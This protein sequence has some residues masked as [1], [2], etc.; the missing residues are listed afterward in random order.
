MK[1]GINVKRFIS[2]L[3]VSC[4][5]L[6]LCACDSE[7][8]YTLSNV[9]TTGA[10]INQITDEYENDGSFVKILKDCNIDLSGLVYRQTDGS[11]FIGWRDSQT[12]EYLT[13]FSSVTVGTVLEATY[14]EYDNVSEDGD[15]IFENTDTTS[16]NELNFIFSE[17]NVFT[18]ELPEIL[19]VGALVL[20]SDDGGFYEMFLDEP[21]VVSWLWDES[22]GENFSPS[23]TGNVPESYVL[24]KIKSDNDRNQYVLSLDIEENNFTK[25]YSVK[26]YLKYKTHNDTEAVLYSKQVESSLYKC[27]S[28]KQ[29]KTKS[30]YNIIKIS[31]ALLE[32]EKQNYFDF[33]S[34]SYG[35]GEDGDVYNIFNYN[36]FNIRDIVIDTGIVGFE[37]TDICYI[38]DP[39]FNYINQTDISEGMASTRASYRGRTWR[40]KGESI[41]SAVEAVNFAS[42]FDKIIMGGDSV[43]YL[44]EGGL[45]LTSRIFAERSVNNNVMMVLGNHEGTE[46]CDEDIDIG[47]MLTTQQHYDFYQKKWS[48]NVYY[49]SDILKSSEG[50]E[51]VMIIGLDNSLVR[52]WKSQLEPLQKDLDYAR[53]NNIPVLI[54]QHLPM[55]TMNPAEQNYGFVMSEDNSYFANDTIPNQSA[56][57]YTDMTKN[58]N[59]LGHANSDEDTLNVYNLIRENADIIKGIF[60]GHLHSNTYTEVVG[61]DEDGQSNDYRIPQHGV[62]G[63]FY[64]SMMSITLK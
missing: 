19:E 60:H 33:R 45:M 21:V 34:V 59:F 6:S 11:I 36:G 31:K 37:E 50:K 28:E 24:S 57:Y 22:T 17:N 2:L 1:E 18:E 43:D 53:K 9:E 29:S 38:T 3:L 40:R 10:K 14:M 7:E 16:E 8:I 27:A 30:D 12:K 15:F 32:N 63:C 58:Y 64:Y 44:S 56:N 54:F 47:E 20:P 23:V 61:V 48:N 4:L 25:F 13:D 26:G 46:L 5:L 52:Y 62:A 41:V 49:S 35:S 55:L 42:S 39:H 51:Q